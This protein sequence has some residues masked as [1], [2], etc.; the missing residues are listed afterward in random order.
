MVS[1]GSEWIIFIDFPHTTNE[2]LILSDIFRIFFL[3][4]N[5]DPE[6][7]EY[8]HSDSSS[9]VRANR[10]TKGEVADV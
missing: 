7:K 4:G 2:N 10:L 3:N 8:L 1:I 6:A 9:G 5:D